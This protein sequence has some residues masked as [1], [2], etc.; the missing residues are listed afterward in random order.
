MF[1][2][3]YLVV[4][5]NGSAVCTVLLNQVVVYSITWFGFLLCDTC[6]VLKIVFDVNITMWSWCFSDSDCMSALV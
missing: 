5:S 3:H 4:S 6:S 2:I 1:V